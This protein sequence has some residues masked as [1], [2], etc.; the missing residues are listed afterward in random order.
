MDKKEKDDIIPVDVNY[1][2]IRGKL[3]DVR[4]LKVMLDFDLVLEPN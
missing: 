2:L 3:Y 4:G 1:E